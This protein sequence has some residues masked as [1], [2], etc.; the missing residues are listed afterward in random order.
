LGGKPAAETTQ[1]TAMIGK[2]AYSL[3]AKAIVLFVLI[4]ALHQTVGAEE[5]KEVAEATRLRILLVIHTNGE[6]AGR[7]CGFGVDGDA[8]QRMLEENLKKQGLENRYTLDVLSG[9]DVTASRVLGYYRNL[10]AQ[11]SETLFFFYSGHGILNSNHEHVMTMNGRS[12]R[13][14]ELLTTM[15]RHDPR[16]IVVLTSACANVPGETVKNDP[17]KQPAD[18]QATRTQPPPTVRAGDGAVLR[19]LLFQQQGVVDVN[20]ARVAEYGWGHPDLGGTFFTVALTQL[21]GG[22]VAHLDRNKD[23]RVEWSEFYAHLR[24]QTARLA[25]THGNEQNTMAYSMPTSSL[26]TTPRPSPA[27]AR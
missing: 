20:A 19:Q 11:A 10:K 17:A 22:S 13:R 9:D 6:V 8:M 27:S 3:S 2:T 12:L 23:N 7:E 25:S 14:T 21:L 16:L 5:T 1:E 24:F 4:L 15:A 26:A 18:A